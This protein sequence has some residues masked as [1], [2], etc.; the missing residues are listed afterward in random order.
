MAPEFPP[1]LVVLT[2]ESVAGSIAAQIENVEPAQIEN[3]EPER[4]QRLRVRWSDVEPPSG[5]R[6]VG[7]GALHVQESKGVVFDGPRRVKLDPLQGN[8]FRWIQGTPPD[9]PWIMI[10]VVFPPDYTL[11]RP[12]PVP[13]SAKSVDGKVAVYWCLRGNDLGRAEVEWDL[14]PRDRTIE[15]E[16][17][18]LNSHSS[19][20]EVPFAA[21]IDID[22]APARGAPRSV[23]VFLCHS[24]QDKALVRRLYT[25][26]KGEGF[27]PWLDEKD[28]LPGEAWEPAIKSAVRTSDVVLVCL[29]SGSVSKAGFLQKEIKLALD[30]AEEQPEGAIFIIPLRLEEAPIPDRLSRW[31]W[32][33]Y[34][35]EGAHDRLLRALRKRASQLQ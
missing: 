13:T 1:R 2:L 25:R 26:L 23:G 9:I 7:S 11:R 35:E 32:L 18:A 21:G 19:L 24:S 4:A 12:H 27:V 3:V 16:V 30:A 28:I 5:Y 34:F 22:P 29:S 8:R 10:A 33:N 31:Q 17:R 6:A 14:H 15:D 20:E